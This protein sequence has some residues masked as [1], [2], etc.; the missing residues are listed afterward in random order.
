VVLVS[1]ALFIGLYAL[2]NFTALPFSIPALRQAAGG[3]TILNVLP[4]YDA[5]GAYAHIAAYSPE[6]VAIYRR[7]L[8]IDVLAL[9]PVYVLFLTSGLLHA[10]ERVLVSRGRWL[11]SVLALFPLAA[12]VLN[13]VED[14]LVVY[15]IEAY[16]VRHD[17]LAAA[18]GLITS[19]KSLLIATSLLSA[20][21]L[22]AALGYGRIASLAKLRKREA[23]FHQ[24]SSEGRGASRRP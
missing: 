12:A 13:L 7:I 16:P 24:A 17:L 2:L 18:C 20:V 9:I 21:L 6:A 1:F 3:K 14:G 23:W 19:T 11:P 10:G 22:Y 5:V 8:L 4:Y 15:L